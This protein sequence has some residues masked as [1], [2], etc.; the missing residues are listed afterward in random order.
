MSSGKRLFSTRGYWL[1]RNIFANSDIYFYWSIIGSS[2]Y[3]DLELFQIDVKAALL[4]GELEYE[5]YV[6]KLVGFVVKVH[7]K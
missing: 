7:E 5:I 4:S 6:V 1:W 2:F 3:L